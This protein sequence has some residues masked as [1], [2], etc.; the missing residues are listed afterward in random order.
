[1]GRDRSAVRVIPLGGVGEIGKNMTAIEI[2]DEIFI[3]DC[4]MTFPRIEQP[5]VD[6]VLPDF[7]YVAER[8]DKIVGIILTHGHEEKMN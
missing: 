4:G 3:V 7:A 8:R 1:M 5:G 2:G 6:L